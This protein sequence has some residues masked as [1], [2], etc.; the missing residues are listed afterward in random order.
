VIL[1]G[2]I[3]IAFY[4]RRPSTGQIV[5]GLLATVV[6]SALL[7]YVSPAGP[8]TRD[9]SIIVAIVGGVILYFAVLAYLL[10][11]YQPSHA[12]SPM[13]TPPAVPP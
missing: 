5:L 7:G 9:G 13:P 3:S 2:L 1:P 6:L 10:Y 12:S 11:R 4:K 8:L